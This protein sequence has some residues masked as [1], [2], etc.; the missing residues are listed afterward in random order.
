[1]TV[2]QIGQ[3]HY[4]LFIATV[5]YWSVMRFSEPVYGLRCCG[6]IFA[7]MSNPRRMRHC[8]GN[9]MVSHA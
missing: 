5:T 3:V 6:S 9:D 8:D 1:M 4:E 2:M 7:R